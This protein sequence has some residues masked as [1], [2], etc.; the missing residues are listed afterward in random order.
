MVWL[1]RLWATLSLALLTLMFGPLERAFAARRQRFFRRGFG[2]DLLFFLGQYLLW[3]SLVLTALTHLHGALADVTPLAWRA[4]VA[5]WP[6]LAQGLFAVVIGDVCVYWFHRW[7]HHNAILWR[8][9]GVH[10]TAERLDW[11]A[12]HREHPIDGLMTQTA[13]NLPVL[14][15]GIPPDA[16]AALAAFRGVWAIFIHSN[17]RLNLGPLELL[18]GAPALH[19][20]HHARDRFAGNYA[21]LSPLMDVLFGTW[22]RPPREPEAVGLT[23]PWPQTWLG[24]LVH[25]FR[26]RSG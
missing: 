26:R 4:E 11:L 23:E 9:H 16:L 13:V 12:A 7:Q 19:H 1:D 18:L 22:Q 5:R 8:F 21:N 25:P 6:A 24:L 14:L 15:L 2:T 3:S 17:V 20:W 10:H